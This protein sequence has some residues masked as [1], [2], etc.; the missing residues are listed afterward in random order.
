MKN[1][2]FIGASYS[3]KTTTSKKLYNIVK[4]Y[5][6]IS[7]DEEIEKLTNMQIKDIFKK[8]GEEYFRNIEH[9]C[10]A[11]LKPNSSLIIDC[12]GGI[13][14]SNQNKQLLKSLGTVILLERNLNNITLDN[15][16]PLIKNLD[17]LNK[18]KQRRYNDYIDCADVIINNNNIDKTIEK[19][20]KELNL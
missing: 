8:K 10:L 11:S 18:L 17:D 3:G 2:I 15:S 20:R 16:R 14:I 6:Y 4:G 9:T 5:S 19:L 13:V 7:I 12:G 1:I